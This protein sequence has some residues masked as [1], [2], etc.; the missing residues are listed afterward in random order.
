MLAGGYFLQER[1]PLFVSKS[2]LLLPSFI[3]DHSLV[4]FPSQFNY[5]EKLVMNFVII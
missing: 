1:Y 5:L 4:K 3:S 2:R